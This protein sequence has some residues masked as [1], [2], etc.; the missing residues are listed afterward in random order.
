[1]SGDTPKASSVGACQL[2]AR[3]SI[4]LVREALLTSVTWMPPSTPPAGQ[5]GT[6]AVHGLM[7]LCI[8]PEGSML[9]ALPESLVGETWAAALRTSAV[10]RHPFHVP[11]L[12]ARCRSSSGPRRKAHGSL[13]GV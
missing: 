4:R 13:S 5:F 6:C 7:L 11:A 3:T 8:C 9:Q 1:M 12:N 2:S 10:C